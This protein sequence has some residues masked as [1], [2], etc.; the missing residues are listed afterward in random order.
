MS[1]QSDVGVGTPAGTSKPKNQAALN[2]VL[3]AGAKAAAQA[4]S[5]ATDVAGLKT[6]FNSLLAKLRTAGLLAP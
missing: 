5:T 3:P 2:L 6:D 4:D 1:N